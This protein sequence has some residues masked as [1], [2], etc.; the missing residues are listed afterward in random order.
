M[1]HR[2]PAPLVVSFLPLF[3]PCPSSG[4]IP[5]LFVP[6]GLTSGAQPN[7][8]F[9]LNS[10]LNSH[11]LV[12]EVPS[13]IQRKYR[14][15]CRVRSDG[16]GVSDAHQSLPPW[17][18]LEML[19]NGTVRPASSSGAPLHEPLWLPTCIKAVDSTGVQS[20]GHKLLNP[21]LLLWDASCHA[22]QGVLFPSSNDIKK[23]S[24]PP[25]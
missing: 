14:C 24:C 18:S 8:S 23:R 20:R 10:G 22:R 6:W 16:A 2:F 7:A 25:H 11:R 1:R 17:F 19:I 21:V 3:L 4:L 9:S 12:R 15:S 5:L 13:S